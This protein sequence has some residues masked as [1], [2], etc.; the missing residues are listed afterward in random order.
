[1]R[2]RFVE[3]VLLP[4]FAAE[5][6]DTEAIAVWTGFCRKTPCENHPASN[7]SF[8]PSPK[9]RLEAEGWRVITIIRSKALN[10]FQSE[11]LLQEFLKLGHRRVNRMFCYVLDPG[12]PI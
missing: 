6:A 11:L 3:Q 2:M 8:H 1:M 10:L 9:R 5:C 4:P 7:T 12:G